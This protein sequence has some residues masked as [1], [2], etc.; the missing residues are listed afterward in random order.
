M[1]SFANFS[2]NLDDK[3]K[4]LMQKQKVL[5]Q[6]EKERASRTN[7]EFQQKKEE[8]K[9][10]EQLKKEIKD[11]IKQEMEV[12]EEFG[13]MTKKQ[14][15]A[16]TGMDDK[17]QKALYKKM[18]K[19]GNF[20]V[21]KNLAG[22]ASDDKDLGEE[23]NKDDK[24]FIKKLVG[25]L[26]GGSKTHAKQADDL[27]K[28]M[29]EESNPRIPRKKGQPANSKKHSDLYTDE[30]PKGTIHGLGFKD[31]AT[32]KA[33]VSKIRNSSRSHA[34]KIQAAVAMEQRARE[35]GKTSEAAVYRK[36]INSMKKKTKRMN[37]EWSDKYKKSIDC[38]NPKGFSQKAHCAGK[39]KKIDESVSMKDVKKLRKAAA[40]DLSNDPKDIERARARRTEIDFKDLMRQREE[41]KKGLK[42][43]QIITP[44]Y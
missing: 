32:A 6:L 19:D 38:N 36:F 26:R 29:K 43:E 9:K 16:Y 10:R 13:K 2:E 11:E 33:S 35:M 21:K 42:E 44:K 15:Q 25:K 12:D 24:P 7:Q 4:Q 39:K 5:Q 23:L 30:N 1:K 14:T 20:N 22:A 37:E 34:H 27:E 28:A 40:L 17:E 31:V 41:K 3:R 18:K 8:N